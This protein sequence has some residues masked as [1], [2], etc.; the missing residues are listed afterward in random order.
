M[1]Y[2]RR[3]LSLWALAF[4]LVLTLVGSPAS[5]KPQAA[6]GKP[7]SETTKKPNKSGKNSKAIE[8]VAEPASAAPA[9]GPGASTPEANLTNTAPDS[10][11]AAAPKS[12]KTASGNSTAEIAAA[13]SRGKVWVNL[14]SGIYHK[15]G[16]WY[17]KTKS[18]KFM[19]EAEAKA[20]GFK[21][22]RRD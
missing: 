20:A 13:K 14:D 11:T 7:S 10:T 8:S 1:N 2:P 16:R 17:G 18:G 22:S 4:C 3:K 6:S 21:Q 9:P 12:T 19:T 15:N 5:A